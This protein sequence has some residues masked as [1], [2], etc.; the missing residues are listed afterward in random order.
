MDNI[1]IQIYYTNNVVVFVYIDNSTII[2]AL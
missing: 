2:I 1:L